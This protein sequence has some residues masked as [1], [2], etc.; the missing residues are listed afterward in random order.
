V[1]VAERGVPATILFVAAMVSLAVGCWKSAAI[2]G[3]APPSWEQSLEPLCA[4][5]VM[6]TMAVVGSLDTVLQLGA[7]TMIFFLAIG[8]LAPQQ[9]AIASAVLSGGRRTL[10]AGLPL[11]FAT[12]MALF[13]LDGIYADFLIARG[14]GDDLQFASRI[15]LDADWVNNEIIWASFVREMKERAAAAGHR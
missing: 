15:A 12:V 13:T 14:T 4:I 9:V 5:A 7:P 10:A 8:A 1:L 6:T 2:L 3:D 11:V